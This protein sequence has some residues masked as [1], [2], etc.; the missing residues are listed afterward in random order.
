MGPTRESNPFQYGRPL[1]PGVGVPRSAQVDALLQM[2]L[3]HQN[4]RL[5]APRRYGKTTLLGEVMR[6]AETEHGLNTVRVDLYG[7]MS[8][9]DVALRLEGAYRKLRGPVA[10]SVDSLLRRIQMSGSA[11]AGVAT[12][13][14]QTTASDTGT[15]RYLLDLLDLPSAFYAKKRTRTLVVFD[16]FQDVLQAGDACDA[17][18]RSRIQHQSEAASYIFAGSHPGMME[19]LFGNRGRPLFDQARPVPLEPL[20]EHEAREF[21]TRLF[22]TTE[23]DAGELVRDIGELA[24][25]HPQRTMMLAH[26]LWEHT[27][28]GERASRET[29]RTAVA[30]VFA[31]MQEAHEHAWASH[32]DESERAVM[33][34]VAGGQDSVLSSTALREIG[35]A[36]STAARARER[37]IRGGHLRRLADNRVQLVEPLYAAWIAAG[38][39]VPETTET[40]RPNKRLSKF[41]FG[42]PE[43]AVAEIRDLQSGFVDFGQDVARFGGLAVPASDLRSRI[44]VGRKG[45]GKTVYLRRAQAYAQDQLDL[46]A[47]D[48]QQAPP[49]TEEIIRVSQQFPARELVE[50]WMAIWRAAVLRSLFTLL[51]YDRSLTRGSASTFK[52]DVI[53]DYGH[54]LP[55][56]RDPMSV[57]SQVRALI[58]LRLRGPRLMA[59]LQHDDWDAIER[60]VADELSVS[61]PVCLYLDAIDDE[62]RHA[63]GYWLR[64]QTGLFYQV[65]RFL[66]TAG[67]GGRLHLVIAIRDIVYSGVL[68]TEHMTRY[69]DSSQIRLLDWSAEAILHLVREKIHQLD[70]I[71]LCGDADAAD[72]IETWLGLRTI[73][74]VRRGVEEQ[75]E[76]YLIRHTRLIPRDVVI[77]MNMLHV[78]AL[79]DREAGRLISQA[80]IRRIVADAA[81]LFGAEQLAITANQLAVDA[82]PL[83]AVEHGYSDIYTGA[84]QEGED[85]DTAPGIELA[86]D[87]R[88]VY[89]GLESYSGADPAALAAASYQSGVLDSLRNL[90]AT[91]GRDRF[92]PATFAKARQGAEQVFP[93]SDVMS[94]LWQNGLVGYME[95]PVMSGAVHF[96]NAARADPVTVPEGCAGYALHPCLIDA[97]GIRS[98]GNVVGP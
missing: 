61:P 81:S 73:S 75:L 1:P 70:P 29:W 15:D 49:S 83:A 98:S 60:R 12:I 76:N 33:A 92:G 31:E 68:Q 42:R 78:Q 96:Y 57:Y 3:S 44:F 74:N 94:V 7:V 55:D 89:R 18:I 9:G 50:V 6:A 85:A 69:V 80:D 30:A 58:G 35:I 11:S 72:P 51:A 88:Y 90:I 24:G 71:H 64:C 8:R 22:S 53:R 38:R 47:D 37:L 79:R 52:D 66:R 63:P 48:V 45:A 93:T 97:V 86:E 21:I 16:E 91:I 17:I 34:L 87:G 13:G 4:T 2:A 67:L 77:L 32:A 14:V 36:K 27:P 56:Q 23:R 95:G 54:R 82:M 43:G 10:R 46:F 26:H 62:F 41:P 40:R 84:P 19:E 28:R 25:G 59:F 39:R 20:D 65:M 5:S